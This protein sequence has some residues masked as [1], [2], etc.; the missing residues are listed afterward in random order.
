MATQ[1]QQRMS[2]ADGTTWTEA[3]AG[4]LGALTELAQEATRALREAVDEE[5]DR[6]Q[7]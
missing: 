2:T 4:L 3:L 7:R 1:G 5:A 6:G